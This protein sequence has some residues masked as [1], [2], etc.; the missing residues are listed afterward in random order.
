MP[1]HPLVAH[2]HGP[3]AAAHLQ[4][5]ESWPPLSLAQLGQVP[6]NKK[7]ADQ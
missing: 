3:A 7:H 2:L 1:Q 5:L 6:Y 4:R